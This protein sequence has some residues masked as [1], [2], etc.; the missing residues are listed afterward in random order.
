[1]GVCLNSE[2]AIGMPAF[3]DGQASLGKADS[4]GM[5]LPTQL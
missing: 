3:S 4:S 1:M 2:I 5:K